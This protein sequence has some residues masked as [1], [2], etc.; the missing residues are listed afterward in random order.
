MTTDCARRCVTTTEHI[1]CVGAL[2]AV[3]S[4]PARPPSAAA[5]E[6]ALAM[7]ELLLPSHCN[8]SAVPL[9]WHASSIATVPGQAAGASLVGA[10]VRW[11]LMTSDGL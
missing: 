6:A 8:G 2:G 7:Q 3:G 9:G 4:A 11:P 10:Q 5:L 1:K